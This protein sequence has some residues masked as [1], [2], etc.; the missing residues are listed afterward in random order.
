MESHQAMRMAVGE[1]ATAIAKRIGRSANLVSRWTLP[2]ADYSDSGAYSD[3]DRLE[4]LIDESLRLGTS[5][6]RALAPLH[7]LARTFRCL[8]IPL[9]EEGCQTVDYTRQLCRTIKEVSEAFS[10]AAQALEDDR[11]TPGERRDVLREL[12]VALAE[13]SALTGMFEEAP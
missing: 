6:A 7:Y 5:K 4:A 12:H 3:L 13:L 1:N 10:I 11:I 9:P 8:V 2:T